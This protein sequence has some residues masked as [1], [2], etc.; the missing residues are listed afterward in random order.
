MKNTNLITGENCILN[1]LPKIL[2]GKVC[3][4]VTGR[5]SAVKSG[6]LHDVTEALNSSACR[7]IVFNGMTENPTIDACREASK[8]GRDY[9]AEFVIAIGGGSPI[10]GAKAAAV[11]AVN[12]DMTDEE[13]FDPQVP[14][15]A[16]PLIA[17][18]ITAGTGSEA[19][20][21]AVITYAGKKRSFTD[22]SVLPCSAFLDPRYLCTLNSEYT[23]STAIDAFCHCFES[24]MSPKSTSDSE[25]DALEGGSIMWKALTENDFIG[26]DRDAAGLSR[27]TRAAMLRGAALGGRAIMTTGTGFTHPLGYYLTLNH[28]IP[29]GFACGAFTGVYVR[30]NL[31][32]PDGARRATEF[33]AGIGTIPEVIAEVIPALADVNL[34]LSQSEI[35]AAVKMASGAKNYKNS[36]AVIGDNDA[37]DILKN[38]FG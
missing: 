24:Y 30:Y 10:D 18:P 12:P 20:A 6:A 27:E 36:P 32:T 15:T 25:K 21:S 29:H 31:K 7:F 16:L 22:P 26:S 2:P 4:I 19:N 35:T 3:L 17:V 11:F 9:G 33:A 14:K 13:L 23:V 38:L 1:T 28:G 34:T 37:E 5:S 8:L